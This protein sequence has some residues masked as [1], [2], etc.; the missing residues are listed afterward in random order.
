MR[1][2]FDKKDDRHIVTIA[3]TFE[4]LGVAALF[5]HGR[6]AKQGYAGEVDY[7]AI[8]NIRES[9]KIPVFGSGNV[10]SPELAKKMFDRTGCDGVLVARGALG[11]PW[12]FRQIDEYLKTGRPAAAVKGEERQKELQRHLEYIEK[13]RNMTKTGKV[14]FMRGVVMWYMKGMPHAARL[15]EKI[16]RAK[17]YEELV[18][19]SSAD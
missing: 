8:K 17:S 11:N 12:I 14:G 6:L 16:M 19:V 7:G 15:R 5:V 2:G 10:F 13:Y 4:D 9:V 1:I 18:K 3:K